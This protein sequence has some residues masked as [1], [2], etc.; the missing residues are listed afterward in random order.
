M[1]VR[2]TL[3]AIA[4]DTGPLGFRFAYLGGPTIWEIVSMLSP[5]FAFAVLAPSFVVAILLL[6]HRRRHG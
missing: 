2:P 4:S 6:A 5:Y 1:F 3:L